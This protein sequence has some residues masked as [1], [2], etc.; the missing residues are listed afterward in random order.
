M[1][2]ALST[3]Q[4]SIVKEIS[5]FRKGGRAELDEA[6]KCGAASAK[7]PVISDLL[8][9]ID[10]LIKKAGDNGLYEDALKLQETKDKLLGLKTKVEK[11][12]KGCKL[13]A[14]PQTP[15]PEPSL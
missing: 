5:R 8:G 7:M 15:T 14:V 2:G 10:P 11:D 1:S 3:E 9:N 12:L 4:Q 6:E 13:P